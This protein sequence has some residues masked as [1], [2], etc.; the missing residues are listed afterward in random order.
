MSCSR[1][2]KNLPIVNKKYQLCDQCNYIRLNGRSKKE[3]YQERKQVQE[4]VKR[5]YTPSHKKYRAITQTKKEAMT[6]QQLSELKKSIELD[7]IQSGMYFCWG[8]G[9]AVGVLD[10]SH[11]LSVGQFKHLELDRDNINLFCR[12]CHNAWESGEIDRMAILDTFEKDLDYIRDN[13]EKYFS[14]IVHKM[15][16][17]LQVG[18][19]NIAALKM[20]RIF[21]K[22]GETR[23]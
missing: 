17:Y 16:E 3:V 9:E 18:F 8:H 22:Y 23:A 4:H 15:Q 20:Q 7:A 5:L 10:K 2:N 6:K 21:S 14:K 19:T 12:V 11:I 1:C 13:S